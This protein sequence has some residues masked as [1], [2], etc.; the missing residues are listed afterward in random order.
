MKNKELSV[1]FLFITILLLSCGKYDE[2]NAIFIGT[3]TYKIEPTNTLN[4]SCDF[5]N[6]FSTIG[7]Y[8]GTGTVTGIGEV[9][10][11]NILCS[12][13]TEV[14]LDEFGNPVLDANGSHIPLEVWVSNQCENLVDEAGDKIFLRTPSFNLKL[15]DSCL[16]LESVVDV[17]IIGG[18]GKFKDAKGSLL[19]TIRQN[20]ASPFMIYHYEGLMSY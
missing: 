14:R 8:L 10:A 11:D 12:L 18:T 4:C 9:N 15:E 6:G 1:I 2:I 19:T 7:R 13:V 16:C 20:T 17:G 3:I 5:N